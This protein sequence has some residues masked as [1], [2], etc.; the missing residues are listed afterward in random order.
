VAPERKS[1]F[2]SG[3]LRLEVKLQS[4]LHVARVAGASKASEVSGANR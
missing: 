4:K 3:P 1:D 2:R